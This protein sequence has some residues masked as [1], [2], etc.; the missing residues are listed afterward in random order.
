MSTRFVRASVVTLGIIAVGVF[1]AVRQSQRQSDTT[2]P[3]QEPA[4]PF[5]S[6]DEGK[7]LR[8]LLSVMYSSGDNAAEEYRRA[9]EALRA[10]PQA[11]VALIGHVESS[12]RESDYPTR[13]ALIFAASELRHPDAIPYLRTVALSRIPAERSSD[14]HSFSTVTEDTILRT[15]AVEGIGHLAA[16]HP[17]AVDALFDCLDRPS[18]SIRRAAIQSLITTPNGQQYRDR[19]AHSLPDDQRFLLDLRRISVHEAPQVR[20]PEQFLTATATSTAPPPGEGHAESTVIRDR[21]FNGKNP[22]PTLY[23]R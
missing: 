17:Q 15:T 5:G 21:E 23:R 10:N 13:W 19:I 18:I 1:I 6:S 3:N 4:D 16:D 8:H 14:P 20:N 22:P 12:V 9:L 7:A 11:A 2:G